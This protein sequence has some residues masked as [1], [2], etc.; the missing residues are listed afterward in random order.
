MAVTSEGRFYSAR[1]ALAR[2]LKGLR[3]A[4]S[5]PSPIVAVRPEADIRA[6]RKRLFK[7]IS[8]TNE[9][10]GHDLAA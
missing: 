5:S 4:A 7:S 1:N 3:M 6:A 10:N 2:R 9:P 8:T